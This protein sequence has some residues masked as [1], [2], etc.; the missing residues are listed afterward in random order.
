[1]IFP[2]V[3]LVE[4]LQ[5]EMINLYGGSHG[6]RDRGLLESAV[7]R[8]ENTAYYN[9]DASV[10]DVAASL[11]WGLIKNHA[12]IDGNKRVGFA[13]MVAFLEMNGHWLTCTEAEETTMV[14]RAAAG[15]TTETEW[16]AWVVANVAP[17][18]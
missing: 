7:A 5:A 15:E 6:L 3:Q 17:I 14:L 9:P 1:V 13:A 16:T 4:A 18:G 2:S 12:F 10:A 11:A 8:A